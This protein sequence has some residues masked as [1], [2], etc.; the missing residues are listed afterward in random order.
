M[1]YVY[2]GSFQGLLT[3]I[4]HSYK[5]LEEVEDI[6]KSRERYPNKD[7]IE[8][9]TEIDK[10]RRVK[11]SIIKNFSYSFYRNIFMVFSANSGKKE[12]AI[13]KTLKKLYVKGFYYIESDDEYI[14][15][16]RKILKKVSEEIKT[17]KD[18]LYFDKKEGFL[19]AK[20]SPENNILYH[21]FNHF[22]KKFT[23]TKF[24]IADTGRNQAVF[25]DGIRA[26]FFDYEMQENFKIED[27]YVT[28]WQIF[29]D[30]IASREEKESFWT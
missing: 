5:V 11:N 28:L 15:L 4:F 30:V 7:K 23:N 17:Y 6:V 1:I 18:H 2:D 25:Y 3:V 27:N 16:F 21:I 19:F 10:A 22:K 20:F 24:I 29:N 26:E 9:K 8:C 13:A 12:I 14:A